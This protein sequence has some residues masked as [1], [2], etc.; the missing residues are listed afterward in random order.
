MGS[1]GVPPAESGVAPD[2]SPAVY[3]SREESHSDEVFGG[4]LKTAR[5]TRA[6]PEQTKKLV[7]LLRGDLD[8]IVMKCLEKDRAR[9]YETANGLATDIQRHLN[10]EPVVAR[11]PSNLYRF[12]KMVRRNK[13][14][15][16]AGASIATALVIGLAIALW[17][18]IEKTRAY[19]RAVAA[20]KTAQTQEAKSRQVAQYLKDLLQDLGPSVALVHDPAMVR[21]VLD[22]AAERI[23]R[24]LANQPETAIE[25]RTTVAAIYGEL[26]LFDKMAELARKNLDLAR[27]TFGEENL[28][29]ASALNQLGEAEFWRE[30]V[31]EAERFTREALRVRRKLLGNEH[32]DVARSLLQL[33]NTLHRRTNP[34][35]VQAVYREGLAICD[36]LPDSDERSL[37]EAD[38][39]QDLG[40]ELQQPGRMEE[41]EAVGRQALELKRKLL[42]NNHASTAEALEVLA[43]GLKDEGKLVEAEV[44]YREAL[45]TYLKLLGKDHHLVGRA[46]RGLG[47]TLSEQGRLVEA[48]SHLREA[49]ATQRNDKF[50]VTWTL[51]YL[52]QV[53]ERQGKLA[54]A[55]ASYRE[56]LVIRQKLAA[57]PRGHLLLQLA[58]VLRKQGKRSEADA[59]LLDAIGAFR[60]QADAGDVDAQNAVAWLLATHPSPQLRDAQS[61]VS[62]A[63]K[64]VAATSRKNAG[65]LDTLAAAYAAAGEFA[66]AVAFQKEAIALLP[67]EKEIEDYASR[68]KLYESGS[69]YRES[70]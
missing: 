60:K 22:R 27:A 4:T 38:L 16:A 5:E 21:G 42:G 17:Q 1:V 31:E 65:Y 51:H 32:L 20:E 57:N 44:F 59:F 43:L 70:E 35:E 49:L 50:D 40:L 61:A 63:D 33:G 23:D 15:F 36:R 56:V 7:N 10:N 29:V 67:A 25:L 18:S 46:L 11:P 45:A 48:E 66:K 8:W 37:V 9:R 58:G 13:L 2:S 55:E 52:A 62:Y 24:D 34:V 47:A 26:G 6:L 54:E 69:P 30:K 14:A 68:L 19:N 53:L 12:R 64:A 41:A 28:A 3:K 39:L